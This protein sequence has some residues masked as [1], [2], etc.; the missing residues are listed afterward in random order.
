MP[1]PHRAEYA[2]AVAT[3]AIRTLRLRP[4]ERFT[5]RMR[6]APSLANRPRAGYSLERAPRVRA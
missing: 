6:S 4:L 1:P 3:V 2:T 5:R